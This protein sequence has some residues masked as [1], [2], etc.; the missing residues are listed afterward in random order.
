MSRQI[1]RKKAIKE[2]LLCGR[3]PV[4]FIN[5]Y[6][7]AQHPRRGLVRLKLYSYQE[8][9]IKLYLSDNKVIVNKARQLGFSTITAAFILWLILFHNDKSV[10]VVAT[11][12]DVAKNL[13]R[14]VKVMLRELP[15]WM[16]LAD[17][18][19]NAA[20]TLGLSNRSWVKAVSK[21]P[22]AGRSEALSLLV[23]DEA[24]H[25][26]GME[27]IWTSAGSTLATGGKCIALSTPKGVGNWFHKYYSDADSGDNPEWTSMLVNWW[28]NPEYAE[29]L[30]KD[31]SIPGG[32]TSPWFRSFTRGWTEQQI[33]QEL[34][35]SFIET[36]DTFFDTETILLYEK[37][38]EDPQ[39]KFFVDKGF[40]IWKKPVEGKRY[41]ISGDTAGGGHGGHDFC[42]FSVI[43]I[44]DCEVVAD[45]KGKLTPDVFA[46][47]LMEAGEFY[48][49]AYIVVENNGVGLSTALTIKNS[50]YKNLAYF[51]S[52]TGQLIDKW[53]A[54]YRGINPGYAMTAKVRPLIL[55]KFQ[56][57]VRKGYFK[58]FSKRLVNELHTFVVINGKPQSAK[59]TNDDIIMANALGV[60]VREV[61]PDFGITFNR[62]FD[63]EKLYGAVKFSSKSLDESD[64]NNGLERMKQKMKKEAMKQYGMVAD[65]GSLT[66]LANKE[67]SWIFK[68]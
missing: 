66:N 28:E 15:D 67:N 29:G 62:S 54:E 64:Y 32:F 33:R 26:E 7:K 1:L 37:I 35:T 3:D 11:K 4:Y 13:I 20:H 34:L 17:K 43:E 31:P 40:W 25:I 41:L 9:A 44:A 68:I 55:A 57:F 63:L 8:K 58:S 51:N 38:S 2:I 12:A 5:T 16:Y 50:D 19:T 42:A 10:L 59:N 27:E 36:G 52:E 60:W 65:D 48:N 14:K 49:S 18:T 39:D 23:I 47:Y 56:E 6:C 21:S 46:N 30:E 61:C 53:A 22:D 45:Y 24:A